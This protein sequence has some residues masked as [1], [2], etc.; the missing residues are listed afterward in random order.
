MKRQVSPERTSSDLWALVRF[1]SEQKVMFFILHSWVFSLLKV[2]D[3][4]QIPGEDDERADKGESK[5]FGLILNKKVDPR[6]LIQ[7]LPSCLLIVELYGC[8]RMCYEF[9]AAKDII[10]WN[11]MV[12]KLSNCPPKIVLK[13]GCC[14]Q[15]VA[16]LIVL[17]CVHVSH[18]LY[19]VHH[20]SLS[21][22]HLPVKGQRLQ[23]VI[24]GKRAPCAEVHGAAGLVVAGHRFPP[25]CPVFVLYMR[26]ARENKSG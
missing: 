8:Q 13:F 11:S 9:P 25:V 23:A 17:R 18:L 20:S 19:E 4:F 10:I 2:L 22:S 7:F 21:V 3:G 15:L 5:K 12:I 16:C 1:I 14:F 6:L 26:R 24:P